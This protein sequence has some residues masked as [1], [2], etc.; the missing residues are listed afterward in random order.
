M[1]RSGKKHEAQARRQ[2][3]RNGYQRG[4]ERRQSERECRAVYTVGEHT[5]LPERAQDATCAVPYDH[6]TRS[7]KAQARMS[8]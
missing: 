1:E 7:K 6:D 2:S 3:S 8:R 5:V 4:V